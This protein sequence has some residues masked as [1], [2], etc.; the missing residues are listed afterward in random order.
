MSGGLRCLKPPSGARL[1]DV[2][3]FISALRSLLFI[4]STTCHTSRQ[5]EISRVISEPVVAKLVQAHR[6][7]LCSAWHEFVY[8]DGWQSVKSL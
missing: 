7:S 5:D 4:S 2:A 1:T 3:N 8:V 6:H